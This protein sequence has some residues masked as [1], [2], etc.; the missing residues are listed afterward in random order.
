MT[1]L[2]FSNKFLNICY[3]IIML[4]LSCLLAFFLV[5]SEVDENGILREPF[6]L[7]PIGGFLSI[8][9]TLGAFLKICSIIFLK[10]YKRKK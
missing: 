9:G 6:I 5:G 10:F 4:G 7:L 3:I 1:K 2:L 8:I